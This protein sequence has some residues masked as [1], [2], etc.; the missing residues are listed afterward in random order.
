MENFIFCAVKKS[1]KVMRVSISGAS[2]MNFQRGLQGWLLL[3]TL[4]ASVVIFILKLSFFIKD[5]VS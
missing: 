2:V 5:H 3:L 1:Y 4:L